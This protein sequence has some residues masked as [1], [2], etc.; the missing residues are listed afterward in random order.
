MTSKKAL[1][2]MVKITRITL[3]NVDEPHQS[4]NSKPFSRTPLLTCNTVQ[5]ILRSLTNN[6]VQEAPF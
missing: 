3:D 4:I 1:D 2:V 6:Q 5:G